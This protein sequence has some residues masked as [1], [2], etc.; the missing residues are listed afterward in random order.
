VSDRGTQADPTC[1]EDSEAGPARLDEEDPPP[2]WEVAMPLRLCP[3]C[4]MKKPTS[5]RCDS[6][7]KQYEREKSR[8]RRALKGTTSQR[9]YGTDHQRLSKLAIA[10]HPWCMDC[11]KTSDLTGDHIVPT[12]KGGRN[13]LSNYAVRC[14][15]CNTTR[16]NREGASF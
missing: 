6:C 10:Q 2:W 3:G 9:G 16:R 14:R 5:G 13:V 12:S 15:S 7:R 4:G 11:G 8:R 1:E